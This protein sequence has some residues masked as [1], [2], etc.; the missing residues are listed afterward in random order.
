MDIL[1]NI[2]KELPDVI[3]NASFEGA[4]IVLY[5][6]D[7]NFF[8]KEEKQIRAIVDKIKKRIELRAE[9]SLLLEKEKAKAEIKKIIPK[10]A[11]ITDIIFDVQRSIV[12]IEV[13][14]PGLAIG[15]GGEILKE[16]KQRT[17]WI[18]QVIRSPAIRSKIT[19]NI[20]NVLYLNDS[21]R[22]RFLNSVG[23][24]IYKEWSPEKMKEWVRLTF[25]GGARQV[26]R[27]CLLLHTPESKILLDCGVDVAASNKEKFPHLD[28]SEF[29]LKEIDAII[30]SHAHLDHGGLVPYL[31]KMGYRGP[32]Y[33]TTPTRD[34]LSLLALDYISVSYKQAV[35]PLYSTADIKEMVKHSICLDYNSVTDITPD[36][37][38]TFYNAGHCLGSSMVH[39]NIGNGLHNLL[40]TADMK[41]ERTRTLESAVTQFPR[42]ETLIIESTYGAR[43]DVLPN[44]K[45]SEELLL[46]TIKETITRKG[47]VLIPVLGVGRSQEVMLIINDAIKTG[48]LEKIPVYVD[49]MVSDV[50]A[51]HTVYPNFLNNTVRREIF[52]NRNPFSSEIFKQ[53]GSPAERKEIVQGG[54]CVI[55]ATSGMLVG[56]ASV[57]YLRELA[58]SKRNS[59]IFVCYQGA[60]SLGRQIQEGSKNGSLKEL[61]FNVEGKEEVAPFKMQVTTIDGL[62]GHSGRNQLLAFVNNIKPRPRRIILNHGES[63]KCIDLASTLYKLHRIETSAPRN[64]ETIRLK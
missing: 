16:I 17:F 29:N 64:L 50:T 2:L 8:L 1:K 32:I 4:N 24:K 19:E 11:E 46:K 34:I 35:H 59:I 54:P 28:V 31:Y 20:R 33:L 57:E 9:S 48:A 44:R 62:T 13:K 42:L 25:L 37:R 39:L 10:E 6:T 5:T 49:G 51:I 60:N 58:D 61:H 56:G 3:K 47:K 55:L 45:D 18:P 53:V 52:Q 43:E 7:K 30:V 23:K 40:Y 36:I 21:Y 12:I 41:Y 22:K 63:S 27:S 15:K 14:K 38:L 26:G